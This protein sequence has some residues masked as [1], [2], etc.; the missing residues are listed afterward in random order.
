MTF[1]G[2]L[3]GMVATLL[4]LGFLIEDGLEWLIGD[5]VPSGAIEHFTGSPQLVTLFV[6]A[7]LVWLYHR[8]VLAGRS[9]ER[10]EIQRGYD[11]LV[12]AAGL[13]AVA[14]GVAALIFALLETATDTA[15]SDRRAVILGVTLVVIGTPLWSVTWLGLRRRTD[16][17]P[18]SELPSL[19]RRVYLFS[20]LG[21]GAAAALT[22]LVVVL[23]V[24]FDDVFGGGI[25]TSTINDSGEGIGLLVVSLAVAGYHWAVYQDDKVRLPDPERLPLRDVVLV[26]TN[27][28]VIA[29]AIAQSTGARVRV[30]EHTEQVAG[31]LNSKE[32]VAALYRHQ[33]ERMLVL[34]RG[35]GAFEIVPFVDMR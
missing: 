23:V 27:G 7:L 2:A 3:G 6:I 25:G 26:C 18:D 14:V 20:L 34:Q 16:V 9:I 5:P 35:F 24:V 15:T 29:A 28:E 1:V 13:V 22:S 10:T 17:L 12:S 21:V 31:A 8:A 32:V 30:W 4:A 33:G 11:Y 19:V